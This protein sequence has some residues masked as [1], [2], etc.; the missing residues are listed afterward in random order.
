M[1]GKAALDKKLDELAALRAASPEAATP[2]LRKALGNANGYYVSKAAAVVA[3]LGLVSLMADLIQAFDRFIEDPVKRDPQCWAKIALVKA[4]RALECGDARVLLIGLKHVQME[5]VFGGQADSAGPLR[6]ECALALVNTTLED[7]QILTYLTPGLTD[8][9]KTVRVDTTGAIAAL[10]AEAGSLLLRL[11]A[12]AG[13]EEPEV[14]GQC[15]S[16]LLE[17]APGMRWSSW[18]GFLAGLATRIFRW[19]AIGALGAF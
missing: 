15:L 16:G 8:P 2:A 6:G 7:F 18:L 12:L 19:E 10:G 1:N 4:L 5:P 9:I 3:E 13:D 14:I 17:L 11:K